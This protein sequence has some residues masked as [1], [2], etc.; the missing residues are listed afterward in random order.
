MQENR[1]MRMKFTLIELLLVIAII[2]ILAGMLF[3]ALSRVRDMA[4][5]I[6]CVNNLKQSGILFS[7]YLSDNKEY[8]PGILMYGGE[9]STLQS[10]QV[11][12]YSYSGTDP[13][14]AYRNP[15]N[16][17]YY[18]GKCKKPKIMEC[19]TLDRNVCKYADIYS[20]HCGYGF[21]N[22]LATQRLRNVKCPSGMLMSGDNTSGKTQLEKNDPN[23]THYAY[24]GGTYYIS[25][26]TLLAQND[27]TIAG[28]KHKSNTTTNVV[29][30]DGSARSLVARQLSGDTRDLPWGYSGG[31]TDYKLGINTVIISVNPKQIL[32]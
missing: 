14:S 1:K 2:A 23:K 26:A 28:L 21:S 12:L 10:W 16:A 30:V 22:G 31:F 27:G 29:M 11:A 4:K 24:L 15:E 13:V 9:G 7:S 3:P 6:S 8:F 25:L 19:P 20:T 17:M 18:L 5:S 32:D